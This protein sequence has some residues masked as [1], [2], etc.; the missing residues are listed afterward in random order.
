MEG[1]KA[2]NRE[3]SIKIVA[4]CKSLGDDDVKLMDF[5]LWLN[6][7]PRWPTLEPPTAINVLRSMYHLGMWKFHPQQMSALSDLL[8]DIGRHDLAEKIEQH[9]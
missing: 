7:A 3:L 9:D 5:V 4:I 2:E 6:L 1:L 8:R